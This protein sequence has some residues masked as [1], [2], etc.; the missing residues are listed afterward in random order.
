MLMKPWRGNKGT[1]YESMFIDEKSS[2]VKY[3]STIATREKKI[4]IDH[5]YSNA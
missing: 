4:Y 1:T 5:R 3:S 2:S